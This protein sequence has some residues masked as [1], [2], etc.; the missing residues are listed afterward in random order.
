MSRLKKYIALDLGGTA[1][2]VVGA[3]DG[4]TLSLEVIGRFDTP[5]VG[6]LDKVYWDV[7]GLFGNVQQSLQ[8]VVSRYDAA[9]LA[10]LGVDTMGIAF[11][12]LDAGGELLSNP[13]YSRLPQQTTL[14]AEAFKR[15]GPDQIYQ[16]TGL[17]PAKL[18]SLYG[19]LALQL[20]C[21]PL[22][23][24]ADT[25]LMLP[26]L[27]NYWLSGRIANEYTIASTSHLLDARTRNWA[28][29]LIAAMQLPTHIFPEIIEP[30]QVLA[31]LH[32]SVTA[33]TG[34]SAIPVV[35]TAS[36]DTAA[37]V[38]AVPA[39]QPH[40][41]YLSSGTWGMVGVE[42]EVPNLTANAQRYQF[43]NEGGAGQ[44]IRFVN[45][46]L[47]LWLV[48]ECRRHWA[49]HGRVFDWDDL[50]TLAEQSEP[51][52]AVIDPNAAEFFLPDSMPQAIQ[53]F[54][55][56]TG[57]TVPQTPGQIVRVILESLAFKYR[58]AVDK[59][60]DIQ[61]RKPEVLHIIGGGGRNRLLNQ[62]AA[63][64]CGLPVIVG[65]FEAT[66]AGNILMQMVALGD[67]SNLEEGRALIR[68]SFST[69]TNIPQNVRVW[70]ENYLRSLSTKRL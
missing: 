67:L 39:S 8:Q 53:Q 69:E 7:L 60:S 54:C 6:A 3:F 56:R 31:E 21:S 35:A 26:D 19:L 30:G 10:S 64:A 32:P 33:V 68:R 13:L 59:L 34:L 24:A 38:A 52:L 47:N 48:Q 4:E 12:L 11:A 25:F 16:H 29:P 15:M 28:Y 41:A 23:D 9:H 17:Q 66:S 44:M 70:N 49:K 40:F 45:N 43:A 55:R 65:P 61:G 14:L 5:Y 50:V 58:E 36:H 27:I 20:A 18:N 63:N 42:L 57:Q 46:N 62:F 2:C 51:F 37:A 22:L 1:R